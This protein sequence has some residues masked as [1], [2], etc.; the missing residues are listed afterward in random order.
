MFYAQ[1]T[2]DF[3]IDLRLLKRAENYLV[4]EL[5][6]GPEGI[7]DRIAVVSHI[8]FE[9]LKTLCPQLWWH[10]PPA[11]CSALAQSSVSQYLSEVFGRSAA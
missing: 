10:R 4:A 1:G 5:D 3:T 11:S 7:R 2:Q 8:E 9:W 6:D